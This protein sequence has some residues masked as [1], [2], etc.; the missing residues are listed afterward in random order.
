MNRFLEIP[1]NPTNAK[2]KFV[3]QSAVKLAWQVPEI[4]GYQTDVLYDVECRKTCNDDDVSNCDETIATCG[5][6]VD[7]LP[8]KRGLK[9]TYVVITHL[10]SFVTYEFRIYAWNR[11]S[12][13]AQMK[14]RIEA[15]FT[16]YRVTTNASREFF[17]SSFSA[18]SVN[19]CTKQYNYS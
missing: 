7:Y 16:L 13:V 15:S 9:E 6:Q 11:V 5:S 10:L 1:S 2:V 4:T 18:F 8:S 14:H 12:G 3:N 19:E 17:L